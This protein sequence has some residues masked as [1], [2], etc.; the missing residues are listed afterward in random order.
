MAFAVV[1]LMPGNAFGQN[2]WQV[3][4]AEEGK[5][6]LESGFIEAQTAGFNLKIIRE[7]QLLTALQPKGEDGFDFT[8]SD[9]LESRKGNRLYHLGD[10]N[11]RVRVVDTQEWLRFSTALERGPVKAIPSA[12]GNVIA[13]ADITSTFAEG[14]P[15]KV[16]RYWEKQNGDLVLK[17]RLVNNSEFPV[18][19]GSLGIPLIFN[20]ILDGKNLEQAHAICSFYDPYIGQD[21]G[22][23]QERRRYHDLLPLPRTERIHATVFKTGHVHGS[24]HLID[25]SLVG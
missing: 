20:N 12:G 21:A 18:E 24:K 11:L 3:L 8:P 10:L 16:E 25:L 6:G 9:R 4:A 5:I 17:F 22:S 15:L 2:R 14:I 19:I 23:L 1:L 13:A 7:S